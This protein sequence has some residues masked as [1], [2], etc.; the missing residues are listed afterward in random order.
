M[1]RSLPLHAGAWGLLLSLVSVSA[2]A[3]GLSGLP[4]ASECWGQ[5]P[6]ADG[7]GVSDTCELQ[8]AEAFM[9]TLWISQGEK[10]V[11]RRP[12]FAVRTVNSAPRTLR[13]FYL[14]AY[15]E[16]HGIPSLGL[17]NVF[18]HDGDSEFQVLDVHYE[19][20]GRWLL[21][22]AFLSAHLDTACDSSNTYS[23]AQLEYT[24]VSRGAPRFYVAANKHGAYNSKA[25][26]DKGCFYTDSCSQGRQEALDPVNRLAGRNIGSLGTPLINAVTF[27]NQTERL[28]DDVAF[29]GWDDQASRRDSTPY[30]GR[31][32]QFGF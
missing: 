15:Y 16:D 6:D 17:F 10:G 24:G 4:S 32:V 27:N 5:A 29:K 20:T 19:D 30:R 26:C 21:D 11:G 25:T 14:A 1:L 28:W 23:W 8:M 7:D 9:P 18:A 22:S 3:Q 31:L 2:L 12:Y 13:I